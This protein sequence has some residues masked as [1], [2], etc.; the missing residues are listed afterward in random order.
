LLSA[1]RASR[2]KAHDYKGDDGAIYEDSVL[3]STLHNSKGHEFRAVFILGVVDGLIPFTNSQEPEELE[4]EAALFYVAM[5]RAKEL[6]YLSYAKK[7]PN[8]NKSQPSRFL[9]DI[10]ETIDVLDFST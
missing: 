8:N 4:R 2:I 1:L 10:S 6:L 3:V 9:A 7:T 5:T